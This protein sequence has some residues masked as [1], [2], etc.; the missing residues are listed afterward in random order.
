MYQIPSML[1]RLRPLLQSPEVQQDLELSSSTLDGTSQANPGL[2]CGPGP[3]MCSLAFCP[4]WRTKPGGTNAPQCCMSG[5]TVC[6]SA[7]IAF[8]SSS[9]MYQV[10]NMLDPISGRC[11]NQ[12]R[13]VKTSAGLVCGPLMC[14]LASNV[15]GQLRIGSSYPSAGSQ[16]GQ[17]GTDLVQ[18]LLRHNSSQS[19]VCGD[20]F[21][22]AAAQVAGRVLSLDALHACDAQ[23]LEAHQDLGAALYQFRAWPNRRY[24]PSRYLSRLWSCD[25]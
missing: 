6:A 15:Y 25:V 14:G 11:C 19:L 17:M 9:T 18:L 13:P 16:P 23:T 12:R 22:N 3:V 24:I 21:D 7:E 10:P 2:V 8:L 5:N 20:G 1:A 4:H